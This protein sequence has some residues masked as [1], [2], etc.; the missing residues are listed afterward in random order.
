MK[1]F[2]KKRAS[3]LISALAIF[4]VISTF[5][6]IIYTLNM[7]NFKQAKSQEENIHAY[8]LA[9]SACEMAW[10]SLYDKSTE[11]A[12]KGWEDLCKE[13]AT[14]DPMTL[15]QYKFCIS[16]DGT[17]TE[18]G[19]PHHS[20]FEAPTGSGGLSADMDAA[21]KN[22]II[23]LE[24]SSVPMTVTNEDE[25]QYRGFLRIV[26]TGRTGVGTGFIGVAKTVL[27]VDPKNRFKM[28]WK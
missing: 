14:G 28:Y 18:P 27:Y 1:Q 25:K 5:V 24:V 20:K 16:Y 9:R 13:I 4:M 12:G 7:T 10:Q 17:A 15:N 26:A 19:Y 23:L 2:H 6:L 22:S 21:L 11:V 8:Y 3:L